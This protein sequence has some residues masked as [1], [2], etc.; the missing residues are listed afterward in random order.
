M[1]AI[2]YYLLKV[3]ACS[4]ILFLYYHAFLRNRL[5]HQW[6]RFYLLTAVVLSLCLPFIKF[7]F[8]TPQQSNAGIWNYLLFIQSA[9]DYMEEFT[10]YYRPHLTTEDWLM[11]SYAAVTIVFLTALAYSIYKIFRLIRS[12]NASEFEGFTLLPTKAPGSPFSFLQY[13]FWNEDIPLN[14]P[15]GQQIFK[16]ELVHVTE[17]HTWDKLFMQVI[18]AFF[19]CNPFFWLIRKELRFLHEFIADQKSVGS[20]TEAFA[21][22]ILHASYPQQ[23]DAIRNP[24]FQSSIKRRLDMLTQLKNPRLAYFGRLAALPLMATVVFAFT[25]KTNEVPMEPI[26]KFYG[27]INITDT[28]PK[29]ADIK[30]IDVRKNKQKNINEIEIHYNNGKTEVLTEKEANARGLINQDYS[31]RKPD[32]SRGPEQGSGFVLR[33]TGTTPLFIVDGKEVSQEEIS[34]LKPNTIQ[35]VNVLK[36]NSAE[37]VYGSKGINGVVEIKTKP[38]PSNE[39]LTL[40]EN[41]QEVLRGRVTNLQVSDPNNVKMEA[42]EITVTGKEMKKSDASNGNGE[43]VVRGYRKEPSDKEI[44]VVGRKLENQPIFEK[45]EFTPS[46]DK[47]EWRAFLAKHMTPIIEY[48]ANKNIPEGNYTVNVRFVVEKD[49]SLSDIT[50]L[51]DPGYGIGPK[52]MEMMKFAPKW[53]PAIQNQRVVRSYHTQPITFQIQESKEVITLNSNRASKNK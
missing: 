16:H 20:D 8:T 34:N 49:G 48:A 7:D 40:Q 23:F 6:N 42:E 46:I 15:S 1:I 37:A 27:H 22:M 25:V 43:V 26:A 12:H 17:K 18:L 2:A 9:D 29:A 53:K 4:G 50:V 35:S 3:V 44:T 45:S 47:D 38:Q 39:P 41:G 36:G 10:V 21:K 52:V 33:G 24:F 14:S 30:A 19:W 51:N 13:I 11:L 31:N 28:I 5:F 32:S